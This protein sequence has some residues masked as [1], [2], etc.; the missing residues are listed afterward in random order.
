M[1]ISGAYATLY[2]PVLNENLGGNEP[3]IRSG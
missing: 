1:G 3:Q 2:T